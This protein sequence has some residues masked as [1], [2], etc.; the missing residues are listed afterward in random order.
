MSAVFRVEIGVVNAGGYE[1]AILRRN[2]PAI[3]DVLR[4]Y[5]VL[6]VMMTSVALALLAPIRSQ[7]LA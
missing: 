7:K 3:I 2:G 1:T 4:L 6:F 5:R